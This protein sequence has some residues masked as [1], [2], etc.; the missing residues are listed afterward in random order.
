[1][2][3]ADDEAEATGAVTKV[4]EILAEAGAAADDPILIE[5]YVPGWELSIDGLLTDGALAV[6][7]I[8]DKPDTP[9]GPTFEETMLITPSRL[10]ETMQGTAIRLAERAAV[11][12]GLRHGPIHAELRI[13][14]RN[15][16]RKPVML[17]LAARSIG[18]LC[19]RSLRFLGGLSLEATIL[20]NSLGSRIAPRYGAGA[21][22]VLMLPVEQAGVLHRVDG[23]AEAMAVPRITG[24]SITIPLG[25]AVRPLPWGDRYLGFIFAKGSDVDEVQE[26]LRNARRQI[27]AVIATGE[28]SA[29]ASPKARRQREVAGRRR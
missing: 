20:L 25:T 28:R 14:D 29:A 10:P 6:T 9:E 22:G 11:A 2:L 15:G 21:A 12:L 24:L 7:A 16:E 1:V 3:R 17:E 27:R 4:R 8:F 19:S 5:E 18:G 26:A 23:C 13:D